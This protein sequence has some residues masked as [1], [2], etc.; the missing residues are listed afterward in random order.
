[1]TRIIATIAA[2]LWTSAALGEQTLRQFS[3]SALKAA[4]AVSAGEVLP[5]GQAG[6]FECLRVQNAAEAATVRVLTVERPGVTAKTYALLG[7]VRCEGVEG[8]GYLEMWSHFPGGGRYFTRTLGQSG[9]MARLSG[10]SAWR[11]VVLPFYMQADT[12][13][14]EKLVVNVVLPGRGVVWLGPL[15]L[16]EYGPGEDPLAAAGAWWS[17]RAGGWIGGLGGAVIG[18][19]GGLVGVL[20]GMGRARRLVQAVMALMV[21]AGLAGVIGGVAALATGQPYGV[22]YPLLLGG[23]ISAA[24]FGAL[25]PVARMRYRRQELRRMQAMDAA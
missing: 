1:M 6:E 11:P 14:P 23:G 10:T 20:G 12:P 25:L 17:D 13:A 7:Q 22:W 2:A 4:G 15:R 8:E 9:P 19:I 16:A 21:A 24:V 3:W 5:A 18:C